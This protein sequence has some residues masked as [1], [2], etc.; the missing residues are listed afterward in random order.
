MR[1]YLHRKKPCTVVNAGSGPALICEY[2]LIMRLITREYS[3][4]LT[5][6]ILNAI[7]SGF[8]FPDY[9][10]YLNYLFKGNTVSVTINKESPSP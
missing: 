6:M 7:L 5:L 10:I 4:A 2:A 3:I 8:T 1:L 9:S